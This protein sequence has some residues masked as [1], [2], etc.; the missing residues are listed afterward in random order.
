MKSHCQTFFPILIELAWFTPFLLSD[1]I[2]ETRLLVEKQFLHW[3]WTFNNVRIAKLLVFFAHWLFIS[4]TTNVPLP[5]IGWNIQF[6]FILQF[7]PCAK[8]G[9][10][11]HAVLK[12]KWPFTSFFIFYFFIICHFHFTPIGPFT[13]II[14]Q[15]LVY[16]LTKTKPSFDNTLFSLQ[17]IVWFPLLW[18]N[19]DHL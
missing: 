1:F 11:N 19:M 14:A 7:P 4:F 6:N 2:L 12:L 3:D 10:Q 9:K 13:S 5:V 16:P 18:K 17:A 8:I 15:F